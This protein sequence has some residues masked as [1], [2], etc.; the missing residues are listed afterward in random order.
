MSV[1]TVAINP[2]SSV[3]QNKS[4]KQR[5]FDLGV[6]KITTKNLV[7]GEQETAEEYLKKKTSQL[8]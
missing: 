2:P 5:W 8:F 6:A 4:H 1:F 7:G 3:S